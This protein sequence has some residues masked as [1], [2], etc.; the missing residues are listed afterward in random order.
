[1]NYCFLS[2]YIFL[3]ASLYASSP[4]NFTLAL[5]GNND[6][7]RFSSLDAEGI[8]TLRGVENPYILVQIEKSRDNELWRYQ[9]TESGLE[10]ISL[11]TTLT[12]ENI[13]SDLLAWSINNFPATYNAFALWGS[14]TSLPLKTWG[15]TLKK[16]YAATHKKLDLFSC[17]GALASSIETAFECAPYCS[18]LLSSELRTVNDDY[19]YAPLFAKIT[20]TA[21]TPHDLAQS[22]IALYAELYPPEKNSCNMQTALDLSHVP[23]FSTDLDSFIRSAHTFLKKGTVA[24]TCFATAYELA[25]KTDNRDYVDFI[26]FL[27]ALYKDINER[28]N[29]LPNDKDLVQTVKKLIKTT[30]KMIY[31]HTGYINKKGDIKGISI[32]LPQEK[33]DDSYRECAFAQNTRWLIFLHEAFGIKTF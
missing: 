7:I 17:N 11:E 9:L 14:E 20:R 13:F 28:F 24:K 30:R 18:L 32:Y 10:L 2:L 5:E 15:L 6:F 19:A 4:W 21:P 1:M 8:I 3:Y 12:P 29:T 22:M 16:T 27:I 31:A 33:F 26:S 23:F 25:Q